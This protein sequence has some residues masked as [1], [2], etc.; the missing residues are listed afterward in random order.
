MI[1]QY[2]INIGIEVLGIYNRPFD[3]LLI[4]NDDLFQSHILIFTKANLVIKTENLNRFCC[5]LTYD[6]QQHP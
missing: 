3:I 4:F 5:L 6:V 2:L 1:F